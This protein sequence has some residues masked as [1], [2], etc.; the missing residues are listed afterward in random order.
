M[1]LALV[2]SL[3]LQ[4]SA[5]VALYV[6]L[7]GHFFRHPGALLVVVA[8]IYH[9]VAEVANRLVT[10]GSQR[11]GLTLSDLDHWMWL[12][13]PGI[14][15]FTVSYLTIL[16]PSSI[17]LTNDQQTKHVAASIFNWRILALITVP[18][19]LYALYGQV[20]KLAG[21][22]GSGYVQTGIVSQFL[23][24]A[25]VLLSFSLITRFGSRYLIP[26]TIAQSILLLLLGERGPVVAC[27]VMLFFALSVVGLAPTR[28]QWRL[29]FAIVVISIIALT[30]S[31]GTVGR[32]AY[33]S[34]SGPSERI[35]AIASGLLHPQAL[36]T[37][38]RSQYIYRID[39][40]DFAAYVLAGQNAGISPV[41]LSTFSN[42][43]LLAVPSALS[44][45]KLSSSLATRNE[46]FAFESRFQMP[47]MNRLPT[48]F[49]TLVGYFGPIWFEGL[50]VLLGIGF[51]FL[52]RWLQRASPTR[53]AFGV[54][55]VYSV[56]TYEQGPTIYIMTARGV[57][58]VLL[59]IKLIELSRKTVARFGMHVQA[60][61]C[62]TDSEPSHPSGAT[63]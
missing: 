45:G 14:F 31:R 20:G 12:I 17:K 58:F 41:G 36:L 37:Q 53:I 55:L 30:A 24:I 6:A 18:L 54:G 34:N 23:L 11:Y 27:I 51:G 19:Y 2:F 13:G 38:F 26:I 44:P 48:L 33:G 47:P 59:A 3:A 52:D 1:T 62:P 22:G 10:P 57:I 35:T 63:L 39:G 46:E 32:I 49:G 16:R 25:V 5:L 15:L 50:C 7:R 61:N 8:V 56:M 4:A 29:L 28:H 43:V 21:P 60:M 9:G 40:N 42:D